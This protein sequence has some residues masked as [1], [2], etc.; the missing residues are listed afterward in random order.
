MSHDPQWAYI[1]RRTLMARLLALASSVP[2]VAMGARSAAAQPGSAPAASGSF[3]FGVLGDMPYTRRQEEEYARVLAQ[4]NARDLAF[5]AHVGDMVT[6]PRPYERN[7][8]AARQPAT[9]ENYAYVL[10]TFNSCRHPLILTLGDNDWADVVEFKTVQVDPLERLAKVRSLFYADPNRSL[11]ARTIALES[12]AGD[13][14]HN[15][16]IENRIWSHRGV[17]FATLHII[18]SND[19]SRRTP[20]L[21]AEHQTRKAANI[22]WLRKAFARAKADGSLGLVLISHANP[23]FENFWPASYIGR[24]FRMFHGTKLPNPVPASAYD[25]YVRI[26]AEEVESYGK[27]TVLFHGDTHLFRIDKP[28]F[29]AKTRRPFE[30]FT[31]VE[32]FGW[33]DSHWVHVAVDPANPEL[34]TCTAQIV[35][36]NRLHHM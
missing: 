11:G 27:P 35:P 16:Y 7:P 29:S 12:Q 22:A 14:E 15:T 13:A 19:N 36:G 18:G 20:A 33:P 10:D 28:L 21:V 2:V 17:T 4:I 26:L 32:T 6:D 34:F 1:G 30:N 9:D 8:K 31:R 23:G 3:A 24:Y 25:D 5:V